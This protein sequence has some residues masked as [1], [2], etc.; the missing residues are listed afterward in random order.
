MAAAAFPGSAGQGL[1][2]REGAGRFRSP[3]GGG[4][5]AALPPQALHA[6][7]GGRL[8]EPFLRQAWGFLRRP[9][10]ETPRFTAARGFGT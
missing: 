8:P 4:L 7:A 10:S 3:R 2:L 6:G 1:S 9:R 5:A